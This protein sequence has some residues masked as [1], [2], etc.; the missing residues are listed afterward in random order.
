[1]PISAAPF[2]T[3]K[4]ASVNGKRMAYV[5]AGEGDAIVFQHGNPTSSYLWRNVM[6][7]CAGLGRLIACDLIGM[8]DSDKL[9]NSGPARY[10]YA[11]QRD[12]LFALWNQLALG[13]R[14]VFVIHDWGSA[15]GFDWAN[16]NRARVAGIAYMEAIVTP[17]TWADWPD[18]ARR[19]FQGFRSDKG[20]EMIL[21]NNMF[22]ERVLPSS[23]IRPLADEEMAVYRA[24]F[25]NPGEDRRPTLTW[26]RMIPIDREPA[27]VVKTVE[28]YSA[29]LATSDLP[30]L[31]INGDPGSI[32][33]G[34]QR[35][36]CRR[37]P[38]QSEVTVKGRHFLQEDSP[39]EIGAAVA[40]FAKKVRG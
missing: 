29:W 1:M 39:D 37:W 26:P 10:T 12:Y 17:L 20:E 6:P 23:V 38:N 40:E 32:L 8:G 14:I 27:D 25:T 9:E 34:R 28:A 31:F 7:H 16:R 5:E 21:A 4:F 18:N 15:L 11:E 33:T 30:K 2:A 24:P 3:K 36:L 19:A 35:E 13:D 22:V